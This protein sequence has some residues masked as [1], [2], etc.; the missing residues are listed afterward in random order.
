MALVPPVPEFS[1]IK[2]PN[3][4]VQLSAPEMV[5]VVLAGRVTVLL[6]SHVQLTNVLA[7]VTVWLPAVK[8]TVEP[9]L[10]VNVPALDQSSETLRLV[11]APR[12]SVPAWISMSPTVELLPDSVSADVAEFCVIPVTLDPITELIVTAPVPAFKFVIV[13]TLFTDAV[14]SVRVNVLLPLSVKLF[15]PVIPPLNMQEVAEG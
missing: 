2:F 7:P 1:V 13:P 6:A 8:V 12:V 4:P 5:W 14:E 9:L 3:V 10:A 15:V 11:E